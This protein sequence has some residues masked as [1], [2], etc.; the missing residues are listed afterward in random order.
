MYKQN[1]V[2]WKEAEHLAPEHHAKY[3]VSDAWAEDISQ[4]L[5]GYDMDSTASRWS[6]NIL[7]RDVLRGALNIAPGASTKHHEMRVAKVLKGLGFVKAAHKRVHGKV[8]RP[9]QYDLL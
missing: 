6:Q 9:W 2:M 1:G 7:I 3:M 4:W 5:D 8:S